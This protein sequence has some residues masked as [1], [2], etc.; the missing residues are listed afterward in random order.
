MMG[1]IVVKQRVDTGERVYLPGES[2][3]G[4]NEKDEKEL[5]ALGVCRYA[6]EDKEPEDNQIPDTTNKTD[7]LP[8]GLVQVARGWYQL[9]NGEKVQGKAKA[10]EGLESYNQELVD[11]EL[12]VD[13]EEEDTDA[14]GEPNEDGP[15][16]DLP[17]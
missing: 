5:V 16:T 7:D 12:E 3:D 14:E 2:I 11:K 15:N 6:K 4:L 17:L 1:V 9:P 10:I 13:E 8:E